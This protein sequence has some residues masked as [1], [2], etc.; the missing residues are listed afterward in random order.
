MIGQSCCQ[1]LNLLTIMPKM[2]VLVIPNLNSITIT[3]PK[4]FLKRM[5]TPAQ[6]FALQMS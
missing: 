6:D 3:I 1:W 2:P 5:L 4:F